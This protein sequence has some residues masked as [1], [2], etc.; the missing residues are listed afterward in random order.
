MRCTDTS[1]PNKPQA[2]PTG[3]AKAMGQTM[4]E[5]GLLAVL[6]TLFAAGGLT[7]LGPPFAQLV[8]NATNGNGAAQPGVANTQGAS[9]ITANATPYNAA[10]GGGLNPSGTSYDSGM[11]NDIHWDWTGNILNASGDCGVGGCNWDDEDIS[12]G[13]D[14]TITGNGF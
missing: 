6:V 8:G 4:V 12:T 1:T 3:Y 14:N 11:S 7:V 10:Y 9:N 2:K 5:F 13:N